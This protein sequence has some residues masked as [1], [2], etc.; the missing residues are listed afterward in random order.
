[1]TT[2]TDLDRLALVV[3]DVQEAFEDHAYWG[4][5]NNPGCED[6]IAALLAQWRAH[7]RPVVFVRHDSDEPRSPL[8]PDQPGNAFQPVVAGAPD[9]L[10]AKQVNSSFHGTPDL[11]AWLP[12]PSIRVSHRRETSASAERLWEAAQAVRLNDS[13]RL[14]RLVRWRIPGLAPDLAFD[15]MFRARKGQYIG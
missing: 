8:R 10:V 7:G 3:V 4:P 11:D 12:N 2:A 13:R 9:L 14:G 15:E 1:M 6:N 5:R